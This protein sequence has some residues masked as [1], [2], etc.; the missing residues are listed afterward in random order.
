MKH[1]TI[2]K[3]IKETDEGTDL[4]IHIPGEQLKDKLIK[5][6]QGKHIN[7]EIRIDDG[8]TL[9]NS[10]RAKIFATIND[11][12]LYT[13]HH[14]EF[15]K[16]FLKFE[17]CGESGEEYFS[18]SNCS[19]STAREFINYLID[20]ILKYDI[21]LSDKAITRTDDI[22]AYLY[23]CIKYKR[24]CVCGKKPSDTH[25]CTGSKVGMGGNRNKISNKGR[26]LMQLCREHHQEI[27]SREESVFYA[28]YKVYEIGRA[29]CRERV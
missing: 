26:Y 25:H 7:A 10:Q 24:C 3:A 16:E 9:S 27:E 29:S 14:P 17:Y 5:Y 21:P 20:F 11:I 2:V 6:K 18:L 12:A 15:L 22:D 23:G 13:G 28:K 1:F 8:R 4:I 19:I